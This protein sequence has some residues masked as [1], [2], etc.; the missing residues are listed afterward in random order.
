MAIRVIIKHNKHYL[1]HL[2][3]LA[4]N[5]VT[6]VFNCASDPFHLVYF[7][8]FLPAETMARIATNPSSSVACVLPH[9]PTAIATLLTN[10]DFLPGVQ[11]LL[12]SIRV[13]MLF[14]LCCFWKKKQAS[15]LFLIWVILMFL[16]LFSQT[17]TTTQN[18][19]Q[20]S[21]TRTAPPSPSAA[22]PPEIIVFCTPQVSEHCREAFTRLCDR[23]ITVDPVPSSSHD[24]NSNDSKN[25]VSA[26]NQVGYTKL[27]LWELTSY[28]K[29]IYLDAGT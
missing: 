10:E 24:T 1:L 15:Y 23:I 22:F 6:S 8:P 16:K 13:S 11:T 12:Y 21:L 7:K 28:D 3:L 26:W 20:K 17:N 25:H 19:K 4:C 29:I 9:R 18:N 14:G 27:R 5:Q 2:Q